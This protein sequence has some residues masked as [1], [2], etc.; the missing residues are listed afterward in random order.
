M[1]CVSIGLSHPH[2]REQL[3]DLALECAVAHRAYRVDPEVVRAVLARAAPGSEVPRVSPARTES[4]NTVPPARVPAPPRAA[5][6]GSD[7][8]PT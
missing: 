7:K 8:L 2:P 3:A 5:A 4:R 6:P 1:D